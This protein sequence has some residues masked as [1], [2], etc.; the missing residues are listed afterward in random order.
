MAI[1]IVV[2]DERRNRLEIVGMAISAIPFAM[3]T[4]PDVVEIPL[5]IAKHDEIQQAIVVQI[6]PDG[7]RRPA[8][9]SDSGFFRKIGK[10]S[11]SVVVIKLIA[12]VC[13]DENVFEAVVVII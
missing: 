9:S 5:Q 8:A 12:A 7:A 3:F 1:P 13:R 2:I 10:S 6:H 4:A 11:V